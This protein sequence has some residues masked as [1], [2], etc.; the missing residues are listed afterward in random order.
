MKLNKKNKRKIIILLVGIALCCA[1]VFVII[2][3]TNDK[4][5]ERRI[6]TSDPPNEEVIEEKAEQEEDEPEPGE[7][8]ASEADNAIYQIGEEY[9]LTTNMKV[10]EEASTDSRWKKRLL[11]VKMRCLRKVLQSSALK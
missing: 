1:L 7:T 11:Q 2:G 5:A 8:E 10:R 4:N 6:E 3:L 9:I